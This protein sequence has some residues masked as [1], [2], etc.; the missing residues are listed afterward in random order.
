L[1]LVFG[2]QASRP[3]NITPV[4]VEACPPGSQKEGIPLVCH[5]ALQ[6]EPSLMVMGED[7]SGA[8]YYAHLAQILAPLNEY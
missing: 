5:S 7:A 3:E 4:Q 2:Q 8:H 1:G 6:Y